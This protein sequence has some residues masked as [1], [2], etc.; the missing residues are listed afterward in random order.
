MKRGVISSLFSV[1]CFLLIGCRD[2]TVHNPSCE[3][4]ILS[5]LV[6]SPK[7]IDKNIYFEIDRTDNTKG[8][9]QNNTLAI[10][11]SQESEIIDS[12]GWKE[13]GTACN[14]QQILTLYNNIMARHKESGFQLNINIPNSKGCRKVYLRTSN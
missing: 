1:F 2:E 3:Q 8:Q 4:K 14:P 5:E 13:F 9:T 11:V 10:I 12:A 6:F 7:M